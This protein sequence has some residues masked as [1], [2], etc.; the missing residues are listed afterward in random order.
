LT[1]SN[2]DNLPLGKLV[3]TV[4]SKG[5]LYQ[6][7]EDTREW[8][9]VLS[10]KASDPLARETKYLLQKYLGYAAA[11]QYRNPGTKNRTFPQSQQASYD[12]FTAKLREINTTLEIPYQVWDRAAT[13]KSAKYL[14]PLAGEAQSK[15]T[16]QKRIMCF[17]FYEDGSGVRG[18]GASIVETSIA[19]GRVVVT[20]NV[21]EG[22]QGHTGGFQEGDIMV[23]KRST[24]VA[25][26]CTLSG[27]SQPYGWKVVDRDWDLDKI[28]FDLVDSNEDAVT[29]VTATNLT[30]GDV[31]YRIGQGTYA[32]LASVSDWGYATECIV[33]LET[34]GAA[35]GRTV[36]GIAMS[37][38]YKGSQYDAGAD[39][40][41][42]LMFDKALARGKKRV[43]QGRYRYAKACM[44]DEAHTQLIDSRETDRRFAQVTDNKRGT[45][46]FAYQHRNDL[47]EAYTTEFI[48]KNRIWIL[49]EGKSGAGADKV[50]QFHGDDFKAV[51]AP[52]QTSEFMLKPASGGGH[53]NDI[54]A[55]MRGMG[56]MVC[57]H[58]ASLVSITNFTLTT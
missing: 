3:Q 39:P 10:M 50:L 6:G 48:R 41:D 31:F 49:P 19:T 16:A 5:V 53:T 15:A 12:E 28:T 51:K 40:L 7:S 54:V 47:V 30:A 58:P 11:G 44:A 2:I 42:A 20:L 22:K 24:G 8:E 38:P 29:N 17:D 37:G 23:L 1:Y 4:F 52:G 36:N 45:T 27:G 34:L 57:K 43:G 9:Q 13:A 21:A 26:D 35:D 55:Y 32:N 25:R 33:G 56:Q 46:Y 14:E 18:T